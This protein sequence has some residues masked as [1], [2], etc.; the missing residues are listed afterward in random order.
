MP[1]KDEHV[2]KAVEN[3][4]FASSLDDGAQAGV[5][6]KLVVLFY[7]ALHYVEAYLATALT[8]I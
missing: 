7:T 5:N 2:K 6:W 8:F 4:K 3:E 1:T